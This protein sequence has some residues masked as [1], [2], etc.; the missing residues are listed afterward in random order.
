MRNFIR[1]AIVLATFATPLIANADD[2][3]A[4]PKPPVTTP[5]K[6]VKPTTPTTP[7]TPKG[8]V[9]ASKPKTTTPTTPTT[10]ANPKTPPATTK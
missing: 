1:T 10:P 5:D 9:D 8:K 7:A 3:P 6:T 2:K 4:T